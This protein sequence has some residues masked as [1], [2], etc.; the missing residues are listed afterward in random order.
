MLGLPR[1]GVPVAAGV[2]RALGAPLDVL[3]VAKLR[4]PGCPEL[5][6]GAV[7]AVAGAV[8]AVRVEEVVAPPAS[9]EDVLARARDEAVAGL[10]RRAAALRG[11][12]PGPVLAGRPVVL[13]DDGLATGATVRAAVAAARSH[14]PSTLTVAVP[15][16]APGALAAVR[17]EVD[18]LVCL[19]RAR[20]V[21]LRRPVLRGLR[22]DLRRRGAGRPGWRRTGR[23]TA[24]AGGRE[25]APGGA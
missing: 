9:P 3:V 17:R 10:R 14:A 21:P 6:M 12:R 7:A 4:V 15:V 1:G 24:G 19:R 2:A 11:D 23:P 13:V 18:E 25:R 20:R 5:A 8:G 16:G 22:R